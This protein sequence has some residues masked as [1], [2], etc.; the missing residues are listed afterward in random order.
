VKVSLRSS[1]IYV[2]LFLLLPNRWTPSISAPPTAA[3]PAIKGTARFISFFTPDGDVYV[4]LPV[5]SKAKYEDMAGN[6]S[7]SPTERIRLSFLKR[8][9]NPK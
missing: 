3:A 9:D 5:K 1:N 6:N 7:S 8:L 4:E 2:A